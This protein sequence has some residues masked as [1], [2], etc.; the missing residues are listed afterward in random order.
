MN[1]KKWFEGLCVGVCYVIL[2]IVMYTPVV[3]SGKTLQPALYYPHGV[4]ESWPYGYD[5]RKTANTFDIDLATP[6]YYEYP[7]NRYIGDMYKGGHLPLWDPFQGCGTPLIG[8]Y[9]SRL[10]FPYQILEDICPAWSWDFFLLGRLWIAGFFTY[11]F[12]R[13]ISTSLTGAFLGGLFYMLSGTM[14]WF[15]NLEQMTNVAMMLPILMCCLEKLIVHRC[16]KNVAL[17][18]FIFAFVLLAGQP[19]VALY[20]L[21]LGA[22][23]FFL[24]V[25]T[26]NFLG[27][28][29]L[30]DKNILINS[31]KFPQHLFIGQEMKGRLNQLISSI[32][33]NLRGAT[34][35]WKDIWAYTFSFLLAFVLGLM[36]SAPLLLPFVQHFKYSYNI[37]PPG[38]TMGVENPPPLYWALSLVI[39][40]FFEIPADADYANIPFTRLTD[41]SGKKFYY[42]VSPIN[43]R[44]DF[45]GGYCGVLPVYLIVAGLILIFL[46]RNAKQNELERYQADNHP[47]SPPCE[48]RDSKN[49]CFATP[50]S[51]PSQGGE[52]GEVLQST[53]ILLNIEQLQKVFLF[54]ACFGFFIILKNFGIPPFKWL[55]YLPLFDQAWSQRWAGPVWT[56]S[57]AVSGA[58][59]WEMIRSSLKEQQLIDKLSITTIKIKNFLYDCFSVSQWRKDFLNVWGKLKSGAGQPNIYLKVIPF[60]IIDVIIAIKS[61]QFAWMLREQH[62]LIFSGPLMRE[63]TFEALPHYYAMLTM[64]IVAF[65]GFFGLY[66]IKNTSFVRLLIS[67]PVAVLFQVFFIV[68]YYFSRI[69]FVRYPASIFLLVLFLSMPLL[70]G[71]RVIVKIIG[72]WFSHKILFRIN[73]SKEFTQHQVESTSF[74]LPSSEGGIVVKSCFIIMHLLKRGWEEIKQLFNEKRCRTLIL[75]GFFSVILIH[76]RYLILFYQKLAPQQK[77]YFWPSLVMGQLVALAIFGIALF[78]T[79]F[80]I[81][82]KKGIFGLVALGVFELWYAIPRG[83]S[84]QWIYLEIVLLLMGFFIVWACTVERWKIALIGGIVFFFSFFMTDLKAPYGFPER[85]NPFGEVPYVN[86][87]K[88]NLE[89]YRVASGYG[90]LIPNFASA[91][92]IPSVQYIQSLAVSWY[93]RYRMDNLHIDPWWEAG[94]DI[95]W[96]SGTPE[97][98]TNKDGKGDFFYRGFEEDFKAKLPFYSLLSVKYFLVPATVDINKKELTQVEDHIFSPPCE[99][100]DEGLVVKSNRVLFGTEQLRGERNPEEA[101]DS[102][103]F[104]LVYDREIHIYENPHVLPRVFMAYQFEFISSYEDAQKSIRRPGFDLRNRIVLE[105]SVPDKYMDQ[106]LESKKDNA[107]AEILSYEPNKVI[108]ET[109]TDKPGMF[110]LSDIYYPGWKVKV[111]DKPARIYRVDGLIRGVLVDQGNHKIV[112]YYQ[113]LSFFLGVTMAG[114]S[115]LICLYL[116]ISPKKC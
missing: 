50:S 31:P 100:G 107:H 11:L 51:P 108:I 22:C 77:P 48:E 85:N 56:Y 70:L 38:G 12:L 72:M 95:L 53:R 21:F 96:F 83:Y 37:H 18:A 17:L 82:N 102:L 61:Y 99:G 46:K 58:L 1:N 57:L 103:L 33:N 76:L 109:K 92:E 9:S 63:T 39:P 27:M 40:S 113:P 69:G 78:I 115:L 4:T 8:Q 32:I 65:L 71:Y 89:N 84:Y 73:G 35:R 66:F 90:V 64:S 25:F 105:E 55:G 106:S 112:F 52:I 26:I 94:S 23:Y 87:L 110:V 14:T 28:R 16:G 43:G 88:K 114:V 97:F 20:G 101:R 3:F 59:G 54:F 86:Y 7:I 104:P 75:L 29:T 30:A 98:H 79:R 15:I 34:F 49:Y 41:D 10:F 45:L 81:H 91:M 19:E 42:R 80:Y 47:F 116:G 6:A 68:A 60:I 93:H 62:T 44:W 111:D 2:L 36:I 13:L 5:G 67:V 74:S 24:R